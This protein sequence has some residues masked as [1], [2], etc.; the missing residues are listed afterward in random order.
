VVI[1]RD[2]RQEAR[3]KT[4]ETRDK[5]VGSLQ[6]AVNKKEFARSQKRKKLKFKRDVSLF[7]C[8]G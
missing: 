4:Q 8:G 7:L 6:K 2:G 3:H 1:T 5:I